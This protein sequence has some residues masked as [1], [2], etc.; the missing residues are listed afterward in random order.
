MADGVPIEGV[1]VDD[2]A[3]VALLVFFTV[4]VADQRVCTGMLQAE[5]VRNTTIM[6]IKI[7]FFIVCYV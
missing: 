2:E 6:K 5:A 1:L 7:G 3:G 4:G